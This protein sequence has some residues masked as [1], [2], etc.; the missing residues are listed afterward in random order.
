M[1]LALE[2]GSDQRLHRVQPGTMS[3]SPQAAPYDVLRRESPFG[4][5]RHHGN[6][7]AE[8]QAPSRRTTCV[9]HRTSLNLQT[10]SSPS[11]ETLLF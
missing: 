2:G 8:L 5:C 6:E 1:I 11:I 3:V 4:N 7:H 9:S 10:N